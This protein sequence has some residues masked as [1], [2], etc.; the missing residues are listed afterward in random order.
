MSLNFMIVIDDA[1]ELK[2]VSASDLENFPGLATALD[3]ALNQILDERAIAS[4]EYDPSDNE[5]LIEVGP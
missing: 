5:T 2:T 3:V 4:G 1:G